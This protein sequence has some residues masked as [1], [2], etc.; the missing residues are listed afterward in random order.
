MAEKT[1]MDA[2]AKRNWTEDD[3]YRET[4]KRHSGPGFFQ[5]LHEVCAEAF[6]FACDYEPGAWEFPM[7]S[8]TVGQLLDFFAERNAVPNITWHNGTG[9]PSAYVAIGDYEMAESFRDWFKVKWLSVD[10]L[11][12]RYA[13][14]G[15]RASMSRGY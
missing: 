4:C 5:T 7:G 12:Q 2:E 3:I 9:G 6:G 11:E 1:K 10:E 8:L 15:F 13:E 14:D